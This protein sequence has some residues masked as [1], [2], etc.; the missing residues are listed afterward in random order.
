MR[1]ARRSITSP[2]QK[3]SKRGACGQ[4]AAGH[5]A[6]GH[7]S[8]PRSGSCDR[9]ALDLM[10]QAAQKVQTDPTAHRNYRHCRRKPADDRNA[11]RGVR[12]GST[13]NSAAW[14]ANSARSG[15]PCAE[16]K[17]DPRARQRAAA[18]A[19]G[20]TTTS[21]RTRLRPSDGA[22]FAVDPNKPMK[23][24]IRADVHSVDEASS[25]ST[26]AGFHAR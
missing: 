3:Q 16:A 23:R 24:W 22:S 9:L 12:C 4:R 18:A 14:H 10:A 26:P 21:G 8:L 7:A 13:A 19:G 1:T 11:F 5:E 6:Q 15:R 2:I 25:W 20:S 17:G